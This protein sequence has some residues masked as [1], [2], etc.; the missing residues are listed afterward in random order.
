MP[1][2]LCLCYL[3]G[4]GPLSILCNDS[5]VFSHESQPVLCYLLIQPALLNIDKSQTH[6]YNQSHWKTPEVSPLF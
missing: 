6:G 3:P 2:D 4:I 5:L 1:C